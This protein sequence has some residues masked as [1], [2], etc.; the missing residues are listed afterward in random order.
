MDGD[1][2][3]EAG[4]DRQAH[5]KLAEQDVSRGMKLVS[6]QVRQ[7]SLTVM[8]L[9]KC[10]F[11]EVGEQVLRT[12]QVD[13]EKMDGTDMQP[14]KVKLENAMSGMDLL[15]HPPE[16][17]APA[18]PVPDS[19]L[20][21]TQP[22]DCSGTAEDAAAFIQQ[23]ICWDDLPKTKKSPVELLARPPPKFIYDV[24]SFVSETTGYGQ[25]IFQDEAFS[26]W[27]NLESREAKV[28]FLTA[29]AK[30]TSTSLQ[31]EV[32]MRAADVLKGVNMELTN[33]WF[34][35]LAIAAAKFGTKNQGQKGAE[36]DPDFV[37]WTIPLV[38]A[39]NQVLEVVRECIS[40][41]ITRRE[42]GVADGTAISGEGGDV[43][44]R[45][46]IKEL[47]VQLEEDRLTA[48]RNEKK[49]LEKLAKETSQRVDMEEEMDQK[50]RAIESWENEYSSKV[51]TEVSK[52]GIRMQSIEETLEETRR[53]NEALR[54]K[55]RDT[56]HANFAALESV[57][58]GMNDD[59]KRTAIMGS[60]HSLRSNLEDES[61]ERERIVDEL[62]R[63]REAK[64]SAEHDAAVARSEREKVTNRSSKLGGS[65]G[66]ESVFNDG[67]GLGESVDPWTPTKGRRPSDGVLSLDHSGAKRKADA[68]R[69]LNELREEVHQGEL[70]RLRTDGGGGDEIENQL[71]EIKAEKQKQDMRTKQLEEKLRESDMSR[72]QT[73]GENERLRAEM[74]RLETMRENAVQALE[75]VSEERDNL[76]VATEQMWRE[77]AET[78][79]ELDRISEGYVNLT[80]R[81]NSERDTVE[82][83]DDRVR[84]Y[85]ALL[86]AMREQLAEKE[87]LLISVDQRSHDL[88]ARVFEAERQAAE[89]AAK[90][91]LVEDYGDDF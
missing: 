26:D 75:V 62:A 65:L 9:A 7:M 82:E 30:M 8:G 6:R 39:V 10:D 76:H 36:S 67:E 11:T 38:D 16:K 4:A 81:L 22:A 84:Q 3:E 44:L 17:E 46:R 18:S 87:A 41:R 85:D 90:L 64:A 89:A 27:K 61:R 40:L 51:D 54:E 57:V 66:V 86:Q 28:N 47:E 70:L 43:A 35:H 79:E 50:D 45:K 24:V 78:Q 48:Q 55:Q 80:E 23:V 34:Q 91:A 63:L 73:F 12:A 49:L 14:L 83:A 37:D 1:D 60:L 32:V 21:A 20:A 53:E 68:E 13:M 2:D 59:E 71:L 88:E 52:V 74:A 29:V 19:T 72:D 58:S 56:N 69:G 33:T 77:K 31:V 5:M 25:E 42:A 15:L